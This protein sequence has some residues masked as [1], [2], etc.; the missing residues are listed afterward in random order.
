VS[1]AEIAST[2]RRRLAAELDD[3]RVTLDR[4]ALDVARLV[5]PAPDER[6]EW[7][8][9][10]AMAFAIERY[11]TAV[12]SLFSRVLRTIDGAVPAGPSSHLDLLRASAAAIEGSRPALVDRD[13]AD[14]LRELLKF[15]HLA[16]HGYEREPRMDRMA[17]HAVR[18]ARL[19]PWL[20]D[21]LDR[22][23]AWLRTA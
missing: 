21:S 12:E 18:I 16:R 20:C 5:P 13:A 4:L 1:P 14:E 8:R 2:L 11:Y 22:L 9:A 10:L 19:H 17:E 6:G 3:D 23:G 7:M 15:R